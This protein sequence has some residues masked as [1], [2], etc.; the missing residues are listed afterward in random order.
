MKVNKKYRTIQKIKKGD[1]VIMPGL[2]VDDILAE[3]QIEKYIKSGHVAEK[4]YPQKKKVKDGDGTN[5]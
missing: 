4:I 2:F 3:K 5:T 1:R